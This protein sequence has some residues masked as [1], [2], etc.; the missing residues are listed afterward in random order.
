MGLWPTVIK[1]KG[2]PRQSSRFHILHNKFQDS[3]HTAMV[4]ILKPV[5]GQALFFRA[6]II[7]ASLFKRVK[8]GRSS[9]V[10]PPY[11]TGRLKLRAG[12]WQTSIKLINTCSRLTVKSY[13]GIA[14]L[15]ADRIL[16]SL[17]QQWGEHPIAKN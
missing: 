2:I 6:Y 8:P 12:R 16:L 4:G 5:F 3:L 13:F 11:G 15:F 9:E 1:I 10:A 17:S 7:E 14:Y